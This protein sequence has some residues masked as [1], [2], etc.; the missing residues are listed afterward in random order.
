[1]FKT[2]SSMGYQKLQKVTYKKKNHIICKLLTKKTQKPHN[3][4]LHWIFMSTSKL[5]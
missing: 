1:M 5:T 4:E 3:K 2:F